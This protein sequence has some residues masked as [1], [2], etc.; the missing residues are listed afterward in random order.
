MLSYNNSTFFANKK[1][2]TLYLKARI[3]YE[4]FYAIKQESVFSGSN[5][6]GGT[7]S[8]SC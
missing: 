4:K 7:L 8:V 1:I 5:S 2:Q 6:K 3:L